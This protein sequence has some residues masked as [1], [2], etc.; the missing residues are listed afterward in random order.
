MLTIVSMDQ[1]RFGDAGELGQIVRRAR[2][3]QRLTQE[4]LALAAG[5][6]RGVVQKLERGRGLV[7]LDSALAILAALSL[8]V[9][10]VAR[11]AIDL[12]PGEEG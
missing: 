9:R 8:D 2:R 10:L 5:V 3:A 12:E 1:I 7:R 4:E 6:G 11:G